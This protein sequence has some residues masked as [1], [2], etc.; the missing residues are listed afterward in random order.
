MEEEREGRTDRVTEK[1]GGGGE[2]ERG[3]MGE[4]GSSEA[5]GKESSRASIWRRPPFAM[6]APAICGRRSPP[7]RFAS[8]RR[9]SARAMKDAELE[10]L[11][12]GLQQCNASDLLA[13]A[14]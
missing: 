2:R 14:T 10:K 12:D 4:R 5:E 13:A 7:P 11:Q 3:R 6:A 1:E 9:L 8:S